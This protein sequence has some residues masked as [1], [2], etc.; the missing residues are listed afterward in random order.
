MRILLADDN[1][2]VRTALRLILEHQPE[3][4]VLDEADNVVRLLNLTTQYCPEI[5]LLDTDLSGLK[6]CR[7]DRGLIE[8]LATLKLI[9]PNL[10]IA[11]LCSGEVTGKEGWIEQVNAVFC[12]SDPPDALLGWLQN[13]CNSN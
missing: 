6:P 12:K 5:L 10:V 13:P 11:A 9:C 1:P 7:D 4:Q 2:E 8:L 3:H